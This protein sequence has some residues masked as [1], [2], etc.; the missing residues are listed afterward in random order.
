[1]NTTLTQTASPIINPIDDQKQHQVIEHTR[2][3][4]KLGS[5]L[6]DQSFNLIPVV[7]DLRGRAAGM[8][9]W[10]AAWVKSHDKLGIIRY[11]P[12]IFA[13]YYE[14]SLA[15]TIPHEVAHYLVRC[16]YGIDMVR[17]HG[18]EWKTVM[19]AFGVD[20]SVTA[21]FDMT[22]IPYR[23]HKKFAYVCDCRVHQLS[24][25]RHN[26]CSSGEAY[27]HCRGCLTKLKSTHRS[28]DV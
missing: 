26:K 28:P 12:W 9:K 22:G 25:F 1:M 27:Y 2:H 4:I 23:K 7:F 20:D 3:Y 16:M 6:F 14:E 19:K 11:N 21:N 18:S 15:V 17:P 24:T 10:K 13:K 5:K 8:Y